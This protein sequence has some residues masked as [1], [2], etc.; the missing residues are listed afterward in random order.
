MRLLPARRNRA[1]PRR[2]GRVKRRRRLPLVRLPRDS[3][4]RVRETHHFA[5]SREKAPRPPKGR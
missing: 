1:A 2:T 4:R 5:P 3:K